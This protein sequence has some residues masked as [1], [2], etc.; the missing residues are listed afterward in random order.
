MLLRSE[1]MLSN[2]EAVHLVPS[3]FDFE[4]EGTNS[5]PNAELFRP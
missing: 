1:Y 4:N 2:R 5:A 3:E